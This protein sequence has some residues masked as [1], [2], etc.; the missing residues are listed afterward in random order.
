MMIPL[1]VGTKAPD[2]TLPDD[3]GEPVTLSALIQKGHVLLIFY[4]ADWG[5]ICRNEVVAFRDMQR[6]FE[7]MG[8]QLVG[9]SYNDIVSHGLWSTT[10]KLRFP[11][12]SDHGLTVAK[13]YGVYDDKLDSFN[14][15]RSERALFLIDRSQNISWSW[16][17]SNP[18][19]EPDYDEVIEATTFQTHKGSVCF[20]PQ[21]GRAVDSTIQFK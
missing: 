18:W 16:V 19:L 11:L 13:S 3:R 9:L 2:F 6:E 14:K 20:K 1:P 10:L 5:F 21:G 15:D 7:T 12:L 17:A 8:V 4:P